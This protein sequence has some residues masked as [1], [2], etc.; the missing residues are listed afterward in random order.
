MKRSMV[1]VAVALLAGSGLLSQFDIS[2]QSTSTSP[3]A[4]GV[5]QVA[6]VIDAYA[7]WKAG[8]DHVAVE[9]QLS[10]PL[11]YWKGLSTELSGAR[12]SLRID[13]DRGIASVEV[14]GVPSGHAYDLWLVDSRDDSSP[15]S[16]AGHRVRLGSLLPQGDAVSLTTSLAARVPTG[17]ELDMA[18]ITRTGV[19]PEDGGLLYGSPSLFQ[20]LYYAQQR[21]VLTRGDVATASA[22]PFAFL[23]P[24]PAHAAAPGQT[25]ESLLTNLVSDGERLFLGLP[26]FEEAARF[27]GNG[28]TCGTCHP[29]QNNFTLDPDFIASLPVNDPLFVAELNPSLQGLERPELM[30]QF[31]LILENVDG[32]EDPENKFVMRGVPHLFALATSITPPAGFSHANSTGWSGDGA[33]LDGALPSQD[34]SLR[35]FA[36][37]A[38]KQHFTQTLDRLEGLDFRLP[39]PLELDALEAFQLSLGRAE[40]PNLFSTFF[41]SEPLVQSGRLLFLQQGQCIFCHFNAGANDIIFRVNGNL[42]TGVEEL[43]DVPARLFD[44]GIPRDGG[45]GTLPDG[46]DGY[47]DG[48]FNPPPLIE[49]ADSAPFFHNNARQT[50]EDAIR[51]YNTDTFN[52]SPGAR[53][54]GVSIDLQDPEEVEAVGAFLRALNALENIRNA[55]AL[56]Q[57]INN[58]DLLMVSLDEG[59]RILAISR[60]DT[61][62]AE[63]V[64]KNGP[65]DL[66]Q[67]AQ[68]HL[69]R[70]LKK[71]DQ[72]TAA[73][74]AENRTFY[75][76]KAIRQMKKARALI[77]VE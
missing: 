67:E 10:L 63:A 55:I 65:H 75:L 26:P 3:P 20:R 46:L 51:F 54:R 11:G 34:G 27:G 30:R 5:G 4:I 12:G 40:D 18:V 1:A 66:Y 73:V 49:A 72:A 2:T 69:R 77:V 19:R 41:V 9:R 37:G 33:P 56:E 28:R 76:K 29:P 62:D 74:T 17:F 50:L 6:N 60:A 48:T 42:N 15:V 31:G 43:A 36:I 59:R 22:G 7:N 61:E 35:A 39:T 44:P 14:S 21:G 70:S 38:I 25:L 57:Q 32:F 64:L 16:T 8:L 68:T 45:F 52:T 23:I 47:G 24:R 53:A 13:L 58:T 71:L